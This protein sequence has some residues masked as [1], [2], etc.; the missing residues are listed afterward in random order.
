M[1]LPKAHKHYRISNFTTFFWIEIFRF[2][3]RNEIESLST[4][5]LFIGFR[6]MAMD[7]TV[8]IAQYDENSCDDNENK[9]TYVLIVDSQPK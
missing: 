4:A 1:L 8:Y 5:V 6:S 7:V 3:F 2:V 9:C